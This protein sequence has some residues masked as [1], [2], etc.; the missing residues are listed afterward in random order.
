MTKTANMSAKIV[1]NGDKKKPETNAWVTRYCSRF[2]LEHN[3][4]KE[5]CSKPTWNWQ[6]VWV[7]SSTLNNGQSKSCQMFLINEYIHDYACPINFCEA[8]Y[9]K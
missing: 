3:R 6:D 8:G 4:T 2:R 9:E 5:T 1:R 7:H